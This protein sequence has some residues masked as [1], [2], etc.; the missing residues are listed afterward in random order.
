M[1]I[2]ASLLEAIL[3][4]FIIGLSIIVFSGPGPCTVPGGEECISSGGVLFLISIPLGIFI[5][6]IG[7]VHGI[8]REFKETKIKGNFLQS[9]DFKLLLALIV[10]II[11]ETL[12]ITIKVTIMHFH[13]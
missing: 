3:V 5:S 10:V 7:L 4:S 2:I 1:L 9:F 6:F 13:L 12:V 11:L 8:F